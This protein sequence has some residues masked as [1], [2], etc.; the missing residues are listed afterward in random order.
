MTESAGPGN[1]GERGGMRFG[2]RLLMLMFVV[3]VLAAGVTALLVNIFERKHEARNPF[4]R[5]V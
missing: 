1:S 3:A 5:V 2:G 4:Y